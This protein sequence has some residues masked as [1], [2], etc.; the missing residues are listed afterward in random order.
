MGRRLLFAIVVIF[1]DTFTWLHLAFY[2]ATTIATLIYIGYMRPFE[3]EYE[4]K[5]EMFNELMNLMVLYLL[6]CFTDFVPDLSMRFLIG[7]V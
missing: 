2:G 4:N 5:V 7:Y 6:I 3:T 1:D